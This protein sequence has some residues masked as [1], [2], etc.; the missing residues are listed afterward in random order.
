MT[1]DVRTNAS[2]AATSIAGSQVRILGAGFS[3]PQNI[4]GTP[5][6]FSSQAYPYGLGVTVPTSPA[7][8]LRIDGEGPRGAAP[9]CAVKRYFCWF[10]IAPV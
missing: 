4:N 3:Y 8:G 6:V 9:G 10:C 2:N 1:F 7:R 5:C